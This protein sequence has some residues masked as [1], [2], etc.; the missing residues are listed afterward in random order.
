M[1]S[2]SEN[3]ESGEAGKGQ[4]GS[5]GVKETREGANLGPVLTVSFNS[6]PSK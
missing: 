4:A 1:E 5:L 2:R 3:A 6:L